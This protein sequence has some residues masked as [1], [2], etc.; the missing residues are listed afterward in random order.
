MVKVRQSNIELLRIVAMI[1]I[2]ICHASGKILGLP[3]QADI[4]Q[5][6]PQSF[7][8][9]L[10]DAFS[11]GGVDIFIL[12]SGW[13]GIKFSRKGFVKFI[14]QVIFLLFGI[15]AI[16]FFCTDQIL[17]IASIKVCLGL[18]GEYW[19]VMAYIGLYIFSP[20]LNTFVEN[21]SRRTIGIFL[22]SFYLFQCYYCWLS[23]TVDYY[24][25]YSI[26]FFCGLYLTGRYFK[27]YPLSCMTKYALRIYLIC[28]SI[29]MTVVLGSLLLLD[30]AGRMLRY[31]NPLVIISSLS[32]LFA[33]S[34]LHI[35][36]KFVNWLAASCFAV[37][38]IH[39]NPL[40]FIYFQKYE[41]WIY[42]VTNGPFTILSI[43]LYLIVVFFICVIIDQLRISSWKLLL[44]II[45]R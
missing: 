19:F 33:F 36:N 24:G 28:T 39:Y 15:Y 44:K 9:V 25:G 29:I 40:V 38:I 10:F 14:Y 7:T 12:I 31:D 18:T 27:K 4:Q 26:T 30:N 42:R 45:N 43:G 34:K 2:L 22:V 35:Q 21:T 23:G 11:I 41:L 32:L 1:F 13:F 17:S 8:K 37:Y 20:V 6:F 3:S 16:S 5:S